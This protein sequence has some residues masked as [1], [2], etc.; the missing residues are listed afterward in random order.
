VLSSS[1]VTTA[2][3]VDATAALELWARLPVFV[4]V[5]AFT[6]DVAG[7]AT[8]ADEVWA[9]FVEDGAATTLAAEDEATGTAEV[10]STEAALEDEVVGAAA[11]L[12]AAAAELVGAGAQRYP[13]V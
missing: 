13:E 11:E 8:F 5:A 9:A 10:V 4:G 12:D 3:T 2:E 6:E 1:E 7:V